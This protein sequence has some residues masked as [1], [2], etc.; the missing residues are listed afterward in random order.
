MSSQSQATLSRPGRSSTASSVSS[1]S[2]G[3]WLELTSAQQSSK[4]RSEGGLRAGSNPFLELSVAAIS[5]ETNVS[6]TAT[7]KEES[8]RLFLLRARNN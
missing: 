6:H 8:Q 1:T 5:K 2:S 3:G 4:L 7:N